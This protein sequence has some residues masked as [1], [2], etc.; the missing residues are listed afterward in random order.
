M[1]VLF[2]IV[3]GDLH[4]GGGGELCAFPIFSGVLKSTIIFVPYKINNCT[5]VTCVLSFVG[6]LRGI[7]SI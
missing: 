6:V 7:N 5:S 2:Q 3:N 1:K 4:W